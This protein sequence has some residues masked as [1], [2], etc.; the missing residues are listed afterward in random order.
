MMENYEI[1]FRDSSRVIIDK[2]TF[3]ANYNDALKML[4]LATIGF[5]EKHLPAYSELNVGEKHIAFYEITVR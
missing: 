3:C 1:C 4:R 2:I 5:S